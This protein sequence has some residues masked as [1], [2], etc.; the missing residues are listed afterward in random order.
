M[1]A[2]AQPVLPDEILEDIFLRL[3]AA[4]DL[5]RAACAC[6]S[7]RRVVSDRRFLRRF[8]SLHAAPVLGLLE[9]DWR[10]AFHPAGPPRRSAPAARA[11]AQAADFTFSSLPER[12]SWRVCDARDGLVLLY[13][14]V[15]DAAA[16]FAE[17]V[18]CDPVHRGYFKIP[19][20]PHDLAASRGDLQEFDP[21][22][23]P[24]SKEEEDNLS[25]RLIYAVL[26]QHELAT[27]HFSSATGEWRV[28]ELPHSTDLDTSPDTFPD[29]FQHHCAHG[30]FFWT[31]NVFRNIFV[32]LDMREMKLS[33][34]HPPSIVRLH[35]C[36]I[37]EAGEG[38]LGM[39]V[40]DEDV[41]LNFYRKA[42][43]SN[44]VG[45]EEWKHE[46]MIPL[47]ELDSYWRI[48]SAAD[49]YALLRATPRDLDIQE[50]Q[51]F[52]LDLKTFLVERLCALTHCIDSACLYASFPPLLS[53]PR[54]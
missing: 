35:A 15:A 29:L 3:D 52:T 27:F 17:L 20:I 23:C 2:A 39:L 37:V 30:C 21:F 50:L 28:L 16:V 6:A 31:I 18:V 10:A 41:M 43:R 54:L 40:L 47:P 34:I 49:G 51:Y 12:G 53:L 1:A 13:R 44:G 4:D 8:R 32:M 38:M 42:L 9:L 11:L 36:A 45:P 26:R 33:L 25:F 22:F 24:A 48:L 14:C 19:P 7:F 46:K 5:A